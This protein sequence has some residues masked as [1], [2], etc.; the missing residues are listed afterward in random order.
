MA[1]LSK[2]REALKAWDNSGYTDDDIKHGPME[3]LVTA[4]R[5]VAAQADAQHAVAAVPEGWVM[6]P[7]KALPAMLTAV[8]TMAGYV[9]DS[10]S[11]D[12]DHAEWW[13]A[14]V[15]EAQRRIPRVSAAPAAPQVCETCRGSGE[16]RLDAGGSFPCLDCEADGYVQRAAPAAP[17]SEGV[18]DEDAVARLAIFLAERDG[19]DDPHTLIWEG[20]PPEPWGEVWNRYEPE[21]RALLAAAAAKPGEVGR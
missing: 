19:H 9:D 13:E 7:R 10:E 16:V 15:E 6:V 4:A 20:S 14:M 2:L 12:A 3:A 5:E 17:A 18:V 11:A 8:G 21:A 1:D